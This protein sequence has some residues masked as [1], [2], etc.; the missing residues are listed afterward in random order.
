M[1]ETA[2]DSLMPF[3]ERAAACFRD[4]L[5]AAKRFLPLTLPIK[6]AISA[7]IGF[8]GSSFVGA[9]SEYATYRYAIY[10][11]IRPPLEGIPYL[12]ATVVFGSF[13]LLLTG[14][15]LFVVMMLGIKMAGEVIVWFC[16]EIRSTFEPETKHMDLRHILTLMTNKS[17]AAFSLSVCGILVAF[18]SYAFLRGSAF[19][20]ACAIVYF[21]GLLAFNSVARP[22][23]AW[24]FAA[25]LT[26]SYYSALLTLMFVPHCY[27]QFLRTVGYGGG[28]PVIVEL[29]DQ[30]EEDIAPG[31]YLMLR[32]TEAVLVFNPTK[33]T[34]VEVPLA[35]V[36]R[37]SYPLSVPP[38]LPDPSRQ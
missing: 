6:L 35:N 24:Y 4:I 28:L 17:L 25:F 12:T 2:G 11:G 9:V 18:L 38:M 36:R 33:I 29:N 8:I 7:V 32:T 14:A 26:L 21:F 27:T 3:H 15:I 16:N 30:V 34:I 20:R 37:L 1:P 22:K 5:G 19:E 13:F 10:Y 31:S 23:M